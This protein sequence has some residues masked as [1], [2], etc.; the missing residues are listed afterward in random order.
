M[1]PSLRLSRRALVRAACLLLVPALTLAGCGRQDD[2]A[3]PSASAG[4]TP[5][6]DP[7]EVETVTGRVRGEVSAG[8]REFSGIPYAAPPTGPLR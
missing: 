3:A 6:G 2:S 5:A 8:H 7:A 1:P 4:A